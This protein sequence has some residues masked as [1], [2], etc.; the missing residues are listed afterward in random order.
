MTDAEKIQH[1]AA[2]YDRNLELSADMLRHAHLVTTDR[3]E[4]AGAL[5]T[6]ALTLIEQ[7][8]G[9]DQAGA[10]LFALILP[11]LQAWEGAAADQVMQ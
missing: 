3:F 6:A 4:Q 9:R 11:T 5:I 8:A 10:A 1:Y 2:M 7:D